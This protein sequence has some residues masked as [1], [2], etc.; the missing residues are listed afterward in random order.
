MVGGL[1]LLRLLL[2]RFLWN[3]EFE[4]AVEMRV[5]VSLNGG[6]FEKS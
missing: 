5:L 4:A 3:L 2:V 6:R 1:P